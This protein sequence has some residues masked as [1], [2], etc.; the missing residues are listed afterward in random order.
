MWLECK[1]PVTNEMRGLANPKHGRW[2]L[3]RSAGNDA[4]PLKWC[5]S[6]GLRELLSWHH[7]AS[8][9][10]GNLARPVGG[11]LTIR[12]GGRQNFTRRRTRNWGFYDL[13]WS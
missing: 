7:Y 1:S 4:E 11:V 10:V 3:K 8:V 9:T 5:L 12:R 13:E 6:S 2:V